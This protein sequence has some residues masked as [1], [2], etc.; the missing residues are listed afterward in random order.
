[1]GSFRAVAAG[2]LLLAFAVVTLGAYVRLRDAGL[3]CPDWPGC[4]GALVGVPTE[5]EAAAAVPGVA[6]DRERAWIEVSHRYAAAL[7][8]VLVLALAWLAWRP[9]SGVGRAR[10]LASTGL[11]LLVLLQALLG[12]LTVTERLMP[13]VVTAHLLGGMLVLATLAFLVARDRGE[14]AAPPSQGLRAL[15]ALAFAAVM[16]QVALGGWVSTNYAG[17]SCPDFPLCNGSLAPEPLDGS[18][19]A[20][21]RDLGRAADGSP[22]THGALATVHWAHRVGALALLAVLAAFAAPLWRESSRRG[23]AAGL[24]AIAAAQASVGIAAVA[25]KL[26]LALAW[27]HNALAALLVVNVGVLGARV[28]MRDRDA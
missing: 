9:G 26:P 10:R 3:A 8:G 19:F 21:F 5:A 12:M 16:A 4:F 1:M 14:F 7:L 20:P 11:A 23:S 24:L 13:A 18:G 28:L 22:I 15:A 2:S 6:L 17:L 27:L 25:Y